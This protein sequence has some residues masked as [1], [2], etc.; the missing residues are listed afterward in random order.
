MYTAKY[1]RNVAM[2]SGL[3]IICIV[4]TAVGKHTSG[5]T[6]FTLFLVSMIGL[7]TYYALQSIHKRLS[8]L[9]NQYPGNT[10]QT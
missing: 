6:G 9:E 8:D 10:N 1:I 4:L 7:Q 2:F 3:A 5:M